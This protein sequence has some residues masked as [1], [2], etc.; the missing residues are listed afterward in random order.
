MPIQPDEKVLF[1][2]NFGLYP[3][4]RLNANGAADSSF[5]QNQML[6]TVNAIVV[7]PT[8]KIVV[9]GDSSASLNSS[10]V[11]RLNITGTVDSS[12]IGVVQ[13]QAST[14]S[15]QS[16]GAII[17]AGRFTFMSTLENCNVIRIGTDGSLDNTFTPGII[18]DE[19]GIYTSLV[20]EDGGIVIGGRFSSYNQTSANNIISLNP[21]GTNN[22]AF[23]SGEGFNYTVMALD[24]HADDTLFVGG[25]FT[26][27][28]TVSADSIL[29]LDGAGGHMPGF[30]V[31]RVVD[32]GIALSTICAQTDGKIL[33]GG[34]FNHYNNSIANALVRLNAD[35]TTDA[36]FF[37]GTGFKLGTGYNTSTMAIAQQA[38][39]K[40]LVGGNFN[41]YN[42]NSVLPL[43]RLLENGSPDNTFNF[44][45]NTYISLNKI[46]IQPD[47]KILVS[48]L[49][50]NSYRL[51]RLSGDG[52][53]DP[54]FS[55]NAVFNST[56]SAIVLQ[57]DGKIIVGGYFSTCNAAAAAGIVRLNPDGTVDA[58][59]NSGSGFSNMNNVRT[60]ALRTDAKIV[61]GGYLRDYNGVTTLKNLV[62]LNDNGTLDTSFNIGTG[63]DITVAAVATDLAG[64]LLVGG[65]FKTLNGASYNRMVRLNAD[66]TPDTDFNIGGGFDAVVSELFVQPN[67]SVLVAGGFSL[68][69]GTIAKQIIRLNGNGV[70][71]TMTQAFKNKLECFPNPAKHWLEVKTI[72]TAPIQS[73]SVFDFS[74]KEIK[75]GTILNGRI[76]VS[77]FATGMYLLKVDTSQG[78]LTSKFIKS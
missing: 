65:F 68:Y 53:F 19:G 55:N 42:D 17:V 54:V 73:Y 47:G 43:V 9:A 72:R 75:S 37:V 61:V 66:G 58:T 20:R 10:C 49:S 56:I 77:G 48:G 26:V 8:G 71:G 57:P 38:D 14:L 50:G 62:R 5:N 2:G 59:L 22:S 51:A 63:F 29:L 78:Q 12:F 69:N 31:G 30:G 41:S 4:F 45:P 7:Q 76:D 36:S 24:N 35:G 6:V 60:M 18:P 1:G 52:T 28:N 16:G 21:Q 39:G 32:T 3:L 33:V 40:I 11:K 34:R 46:L 13:G 23:D 64:G 67:G 44:N 27:Y 70:L 15:A 74:G 25:N